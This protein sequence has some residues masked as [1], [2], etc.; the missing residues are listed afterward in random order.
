VKAQVR[1]CKRYRQL[2]ISPL[3]A[4]GRLEHAQR[5]LPGLAPGHEGDDPRVVMG[6]CP[7][8]SRG[9]EGHVSLGFGHSNTDKNLGRQTN[10]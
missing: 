8:C 6:E 9:A 2:I 7:A 10:A 3:V 4:P 1:L 5:G